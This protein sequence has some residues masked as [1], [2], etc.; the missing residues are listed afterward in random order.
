MLIMDSNGI[1]R[2]ANKM[3]PCFTPASR[4]EDDTLV[5]TP[6]PRP[7]V[8]GDN[9]RGKDPMLVGD[10]GDASADVGEGRWPTLACRSFSLIRSATVPVLR[11]LAE[12]SRGRRL[13]SRL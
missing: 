11:R 12:G 10:D 1:A 9:N 8:R 5:G 7:D 6:S 13:D 4:L 3:G 2:P